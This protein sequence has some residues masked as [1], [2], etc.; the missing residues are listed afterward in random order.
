MAEAAAWEVVCQHAQRELS[1]CREEKA[2][3]ASRFAKLPWVDPGPSQIPL[4]SDPPHW[5]I[6]RLRTRYR[7]LERKTVYLEHWG[8]L[9]N[10]LHSKVVA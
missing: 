6:R 8:R 3:I 7:A 4:E 10:F 5:P 9:A 1:D 2:S